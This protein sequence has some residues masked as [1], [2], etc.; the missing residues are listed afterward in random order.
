MLEPEM[1]YAD[2]T[3]LMDLSEEMIRY[4]LRRL[5]RECSNEIAFFNRYINTEVMSR[6]SKAI[7]APFIRITYTDCIEIFQSLQ[8]KSPLPP[9][10]INHPDS[11]HAILKQSEWERV[12]LAAANVSLS[13]LKWGD[14]FRKEHEKFLCDV[15][16]SGTMVFVTHFPSEFKAFYMRRDDPL[17]FNTGVTSTECFLLSFC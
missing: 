4:A 8:S 7:E 10:S 17:G 9:K 1:A 3:T 15:V 5:Q 13:P 14:D 12:S 6:L 16:F 2:L 11:R